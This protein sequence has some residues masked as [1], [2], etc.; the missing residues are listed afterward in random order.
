MNPPLKTALLVTTHEGQP[1]VAELE[2]QAA[3]DMRPR[4]DYVELAKR[5]DCDVID[6][7]HMAERSSAPAR[8]LSRVNMV[9]AQ[10]LEAFVRKDRY[11]H[12]LA[13]ADRLGLPLALLFKLSGGRRDLAMVSTWATRP[14]KAVFFSRLKV[15]S[16]LRLIFARSL[17]AELIRAR[18]GVSGEKLQVEPR[19]VDERFWRPLEVKPGNLVCSVGWEARDYPTLLEAMRG[20]D[21][22]AE[23][24]VGAIA[25]P[26]LGDTRGP[27]AES[28][29]ALSGGGLPP[30]VTLVQKKPRE[31]RDLYAR[32]KFVVIPVKDVEFDA[33]VT[34][35]TEAMASGKPVIATRTRA[36]GDLFE[37]GVQ[38]LYVPPGDPAAMRQAIEALDGDPARVRRMGEAARALVLKHHTL[39][40][41]MDRFAA[42]VSGEGVA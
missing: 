4:K 37:D 6:G 39:D 5:L 9:A 19:G 36:I 3:A 7:Q 35:T 40:M 15:Q 2:R 14:R 38:G 16:H 24:A 11:R 1:T 22:S 10:V 20:L 33:G 27:V 31:L 26:L 30:N 25:K 23:L 18:L 41:C 28:M 12:I 8:A 32:S 13:W 29:R 34:A 21:L 42:L 17:Q